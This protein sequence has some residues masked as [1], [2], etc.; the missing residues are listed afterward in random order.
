[1]IPGRAFFPQKRLLVLCAFLALSGCAILEPRRATTDETASSRSQEPE[2]DRGVEVGE[3]SS[4]RG[5]V[6]ARALEDQ[7][8]ANYQ[9]L[10]KKAR[11]KKTLV[12]NDDP[13][14][15]RLN[16]IA[17]RIIPFA[18]RFNPDITEWKWEINL[19]R[20]KD[21]NAF[22]MP[23]G[24]IAFYT[25]LIE[26]LKATDDELAIVMGH[27]MAHALREH[28]RAQIAK[29]KVTSLGA[30]LLGTFVSGG[31]YANAFGFAG[32]LLT[33][34]FSRSDESEADLVGLD[35][36]ARAG[37]DPRAG[38]SL[39]QKMAEASKSSFSLSWM[40]THPDNA[41]RIMDIEAQLPKVMPLYE[42]AQAGARAQ[43]ASDPQ[44]KRAAPAAQKPA[45]ES[46]K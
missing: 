21:I 23:G 8:A 30:S 2:E 11:E 20:S 38:V 31:K 32:N 22:C 42:K 17:Q 45:S 39:W 14:T 43:I 12:G 18:K 28:A 34:K 44:R 46:R 9:A 1:M 40:S 24:K 6:S 27:E 36:A 4:M 13:Q 16:V 5:L 3:M 33:L 26:T 25:G 35:L 7:A 41:N 15:R 37:Y 29:S 19:I 10:L